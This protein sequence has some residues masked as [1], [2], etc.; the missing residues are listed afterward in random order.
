MAKSPC[1]TNRNV[2]MGQHPQNRRAS[3]GTRVHFQPASLMGNMRAQAQSRG[4]TFAITAPWRR[5]AVKTPI[6][7]L[8][9]DL[10][11]ARILLIAWLRTSIIKTL[12]EFPFE[13]YL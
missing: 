6:A 12:G 8:S 1:I 13:I 3:P 7:S 4:A 5:R 2:I 9:D 10:R 11:P